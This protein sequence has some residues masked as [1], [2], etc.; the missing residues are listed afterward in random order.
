MARV[1]AYAFRC[2]VTKTGPRN[3]QQTEQHNYTN[4]PSAMSYRD[5][6]L[7]RPNTKKVEVVL[8]LDEATAQET[9]ASEGEQSDLSSAV[10][11]ARS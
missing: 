5:T 6:A 3:T 4:L 1:P 11:R 9:L 10:A 2:T 8:V 7:K